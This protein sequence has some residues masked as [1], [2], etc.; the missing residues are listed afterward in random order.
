MP[1]HLKFKSVI[2]SPE[3]QKVDIFMKIYLASKSPR[4][5][6]LLTQMGVEFELLSVDIPEVLYPNELPK[7][8]SMRITEEK[9]TYAWQSLLES[10]KPILPVLCADTEVVQDNKV[11]GKPRDYQDAFDMIKS[12]AGRSH[13]V[14][15]SVGIRYHQHQK[16]LLNETW[17]S[18]ASMSDADIHRYLSENTYQDKAG[19]YGIQS[20]IGQYITKIDGCFYAVMGLPL[21]SVRKLLDT[22]DR[23][24]SE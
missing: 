7:D 6:E 20:F 11:Y 21:H 3:K 19:A 9:L 5:R 18:F 15:T 14:L 12:Y 4:R 13:L 22:L 16:I 10:K 8:Y 24:H 2:N 1:L 23:Q 17:V